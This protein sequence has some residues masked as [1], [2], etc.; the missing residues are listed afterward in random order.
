MLG[1]IAL[2]RIWLILRGILTLVRIPGRRILRILRILLRLLFRLLLRVLLRLLLRVLLRLLLWLLWLLWLVLRLNGG[3]ACML[4]NGMAGMA[5]LAVG[6]VAGMARLTVDD[7]RI[8]AVRAHPLPP[9]VLGAAI[10]AGN[11]CLV[12]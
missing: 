10:R 12:H 1:L 4:E 3:N 8:T 11:C 7:K 2:L 6:G 9:Q 5:V